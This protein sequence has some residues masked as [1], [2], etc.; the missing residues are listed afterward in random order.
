MNYGIHINNLDKIDKVIKYGGNYIQLMGS[1]ND[2][3]INYILRKNINIVLHLSY[4]INIASYWDRF[5]SWILEMMNEIELANELKAKYVVVHVGKQKNKKIGECY[6]NMISSLLYVH[7]QTKKMDVKILLETPPGVGTD[8]CYKIDDFAYFYN[9][10]KN[11]PNKAFSE[12]FGICIDTCHIYTAGYD[13]ANF[14]I[15]MSYIKSFD[16]LIGIEHILLVHL[17]DSKNE[18]GAKIDKHANLNEG[19]IGSNIIPIIKYFAKKNIPM[20]VEV[21]GIKKNLTFI[22]KVL[23][24][25]KDK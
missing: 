21:H 7:E 14:E 11:H 18:L 10:I 8:L 23:K 16:K 9:K 22:R 24:I 3:E 5:S 17:N 20:I 15:F 1:F 6:N 19:F 2:K 25:E 13:I 4:T 12:R